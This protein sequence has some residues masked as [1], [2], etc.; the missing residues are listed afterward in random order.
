MTGPNTNVTNRL[1]SRIGLQEVEVFD[2]EYPKRP[3][4]LWLGEV[5]LPDNARPLV[6]GS[7]FMLAVRRDSL[8][9]ETVALFDLRRAYF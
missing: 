9:V 3:D 5:R 1:A 6:I 7:D 4:G 8:D 2:V